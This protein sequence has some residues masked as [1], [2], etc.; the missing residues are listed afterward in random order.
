MQIEVT[1]DRFGFHVSDGKEGHPPALAYVQFY[2]KSSA[3]SRVADLAISPHLTTPA[4]VDRFIDSSIAALQA[5]RD[6]AKG[7]L[8]VAERA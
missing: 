6:D 1:K 8:K 2:V 4:E 3:L 5:I 7:A